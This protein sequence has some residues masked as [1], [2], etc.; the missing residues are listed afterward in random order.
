MATTMAVVIGAIA[1][2][3]YNHWVAKTAYAETAKR[4]GVLLASGLIVGESLFGVFTAAVIVSTN[5]AEPFGLVPADFPW[6]AMLVGVIAFA[7]VVYALY[8]WTKSRAGRV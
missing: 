7:A 6:P 5:K 3:F 1:G 8:A 2:A 4:L